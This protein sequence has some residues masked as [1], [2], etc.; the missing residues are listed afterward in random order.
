MSKLKTFEDILSAEG[1][2][3]KDGFIRYYVVV[4]VIKEAQ[5]NAIEVALELAANHGHVAMIDL[6]V[7]KPTGFHYRRNGFAYQIDKDSIL[8]L[9]HSDELKV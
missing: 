7:E 9:K 4:E 6:D 5:R 2:D 1:I 3:F 8:N